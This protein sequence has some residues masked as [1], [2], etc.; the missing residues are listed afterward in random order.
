MKREDLKAMNLS[1]EQ[2]NQIPY[3]KPHFTNI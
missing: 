3:S 1:D 2:V